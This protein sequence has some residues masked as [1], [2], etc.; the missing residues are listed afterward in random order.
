MRVMKKFSQLLTEGQK[1][2]VMILF[3]MMLFGAA[4]EVCGVSLMLPLVTAIMDENIIAGNAVVA[5]ICRRLHIRNHVGFV[6]LCILS[7]LFL[8]IVKTGYLVFEYYMQYRFIGN[9][10]FTVQERLLDAYL[11]RPYESFLT[12]QS[13]EVVRIVQDD[14]EKTFG[15]LAALLLAASETV[16]SAALLLAVFVINPVMTG[17]V[18]LS[19]ILAM[20]FIV[21]AVRPVLQWQGRRYQESYAQNNKWLLQA[22]SGIKEIKAAQTERFFMENYAAYGRQR[23]RAFRI[24]NTLQNVPRFLIEAAS[25]CSM[26][27]I[28]G[29]M[30]LFGQDVQQLLPALSAFVM[31]AVKLLPSANRIVGAVNQIAFSEPALDNM[32]NNLK[33][34]PAV[35]N[36]DRNECQGKSVQEGENPLELK[37]EIRLSGISYFYP[38]SSQAVF[39]HM[40]LSIPVGSSIGIIGASGAGKTT[41]VDIL[42]G[43]LRP[44]EGQVLADGAD[45]SSSLS[46]WLAH[47][48]Y[49]PQIIFM[50]DGTMRDNVIFGR[51]RIS[52]NDDDVWDALEKAQLADFVRGLPKGLDTEIGERGVRLSGGQRQRIGIAR[53]LFTDPEVL[54]FDEA[55]SAL[56][57]DTEEAVMQAIH[58]LHGKKTMVIIAH[59]LTTIAGCD[60]VYCA[61]DGKFLKE[62]QKD[63]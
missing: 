44:Q 47:I 60:A 3:F 34:I 50:L 14:T 5:D 11:H 25:I 58:A 17:F 43:F 1:K 37:K 62:K 9:S 26:L 57:N 19:M 24:N 38:G 42:L 18:A 6:M 61:V 27:F 12:I 56:D 52:Q 59:R 7:L 15:M 10:Q 20:L 45:V 39:Q 23:V 8:Y 13:G 63:D 54:I 49:I 36:A 16:V 28:I 2:K 41:A 51:K 53:A 48:G 29:G 46:G 31:A 32:L 33:E 4:L 55:T 22:I 21:K 35:Q 40:D 30:L